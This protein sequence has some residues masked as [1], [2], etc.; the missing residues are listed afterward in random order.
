MTTERCRCRHLLGT[1]GLD[2]RTAT[3]TCPPRTPARPRS[4][5]QHNGLGRPRRHHRH[6]RLRHRPGQHSA[7]H[8]HD[9]GQE[10]VI[11]WFT[12]TDPV[13]E[14]DLVAGGDA[15]WL[16][17]VQDA[18]GP[19]FSSRRPAAAADLHAASR[20]LQVPHPRRGAAERRR[21]R[22]AATPTATVTPPTGSASSTSRR[23][24]TSGSTPTTTRSFTDETAMQPVQGSSG[25]I[26]HI[27]TD[28]P[29][30]RPRV[31]PVRRRLPRARRLH[32]DRRPR[33]PVQGRHRRRHRHR[34]RR[35]RLARR[36]H[37][38]R[39]H[40]VRRHRWTARRPAPSSSRPA[41]ATS[42]PA[43]PP[44]RSPTAWSSWPRTGVDI[45]N[46]S[47]GGLPALND[48]DNARAELYNRIINK[49]G[50][51]IVI[52]AGNSS[53][54]LNTIGDPSVAT[55]VVSVGADITKETWAANYG[56]DVDRTSPMIMPF[57]SGGPREDGGFKP[58]ITAPGAAISTTPTVA[59]RLPGRRG[60]L[61]PAGRLLDAAGHL[62]GV[63]AGDRL[64]W[65][66]CSRRPS[67]RCRRAR[68]PP[69]LRRAV[70][71]SAVWNYAIPAF[72]QGRGQIDVPAAWE[73][74]PG[75]T[76]TP[77]RITTSA[78]VCTEVWN[79]AR[80]D[81]RAPASTTA[82]P[83]TRAARRQARRKSYDVTLKRTTGPGEVG[84]LRAAAQGQRRHLLGRRRRRCR[85]R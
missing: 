74:A 50:V 62:D 79:V 71:S 15:T 84:H 48:G 72:L 69:P 32:G 9:P 52:S 40:A 75:R 31:D 4:R 39:A 55:D 81:L 36:R 42:A 73:P 58:N 26:G 37:R 2:A 85:C 3:P 22:A 19:T 66:C 11:D 38:R 25:Q 35:A 63:P 13:T 82:A 56:S 46:M 60:R 76:S 29:A 80:Q 47:I 12:A 53:N 51:Q 45:I 28:K 17:M 16:P 6:P 59:A 34:V 65:R 20:Q 7:A 49:L 57:S 1:V 30:T 54:A 24:T 23:P 14:G 8:D 10:K 21:L 5:P 83:L 78:P 67:S 68:R 27:G 33:R 43:A 70:Y 18:T 44:P 64:R 41:P 61:R 77:S